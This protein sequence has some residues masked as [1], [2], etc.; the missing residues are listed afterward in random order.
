MIVENKC[1]IIDYLLLLKLMTKKYDFGNEFY[2]SWVSY[3][4]PTI[5]HTNF[6]MTNTNCY[7]NI[8]FFDSFI[9][10]FNISNSFVLKH[11]KNS[12]IKIIFNEET[13]FD[14]H[15]IKIQII[16]YKAPYYIFYDCYD[17]EIPYNELSK[18]IQ[19]NIDDFTYIN[20]RS[21][22]NSIYNDNR[23]I[24]MTSFAYSD[25][26]KRNLLYELFKKICLRL[27][28]IKF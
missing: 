10:T 6:K 3:L 19:I 8:Y 12:S 26:I 28:K 27:I 7:S 22:C 13:H 17:F 4:L 24:L 2:K 25:Y 21:L 11:Q 1:K 5:N 18:I 14:I 15:I 9:N 23:G 16:V 20:F